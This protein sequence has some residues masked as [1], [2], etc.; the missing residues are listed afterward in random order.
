[1]T[2]FD[3]SLTK[4]SDRDFYQSG[5]KEPH[6]GITKVLLKE[7]PELRQFL[8]QR[9]PWSFAIG[10]LAVGGHLA[11]A[12]AVSG[13][14]WWV[15]I[16]TAFFIGTV[17]SIS[18]GA[19]VHEATHNLIF[20]SKT[21]NMIAGIVVNMGMFVPSFVSFAKYHLKHHSFQ[22][23]HEL[24]AAMPS[25]LEARLVRNVWWR[26]I[27][28]MLS[29]P[30]WQM[31]RTY[32]V[33][34]VRFFDGWVLVNWIA[35][36]AI[37]AFVF[38]AWGPNA[39]IYLAASFWLGYGLSVMGA[40]IIQ[41]HFIIKPPQETYSYYGI[42]NLPGLN[43]AHHNEHHDFP[44]APWNHLPKI[45]RIAGDYYNNLHY[46]TSYTRLMLRFLFSPKMS[47]YDRVERRERGDVGLDAPVQP[48]LDAIG[49]QS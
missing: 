34:E 36:F 16:L 25:E 22:G 9:N 32:R 21:G 37:D 3:I 44:S 18:F 28:W 49:N 24:D 47:L 14:P 10:V 29:Y 43:V 31:I 15:A 40:R 30:G 42:A 12:W 46:H 4:P 7:Y 8:G 6:R 39:L 19:L 48:D 23:V 26:K 11:V 13:Y 45:R 27:L 17:F 2:S 41:E 5:V 38:I 35:V 20:R 33:K 1:M